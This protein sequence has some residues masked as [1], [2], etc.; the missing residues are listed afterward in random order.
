MAVD[1]DFPTGYHDND[2]V[3]ARTHRQ[4]FP[5]TPAPLPLYSAADAGDGDS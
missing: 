2:G 4:A 1:G 5:P 3:V